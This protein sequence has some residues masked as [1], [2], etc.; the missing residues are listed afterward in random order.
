[1]AKYSYNLIFIHSL[2]LHKLNLPGVLRVNEYVTQAEL[3]NYFYVW[4]RDFSENEN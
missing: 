4:S 2:N 1:L 3:N